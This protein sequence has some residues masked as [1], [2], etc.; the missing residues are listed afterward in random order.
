MRDSGDEY[1]GR[2]LKPDTRLL[3]AASYRPSTRSLSVVYDDGEIAE[4]SVGVLMLPDGALI[5]DV[6][7][8]EFRRGIELQLVDGTV[9]DVA[10][11]YITWLTNEAYRHQYPPD[12][13]PRIGANVA[14]LRKQRGMSQGEL[15][16]AAGI[17]APNVSRLEAGKHVP[18]LDVLLRI[19]QA[20]NVTLGK[21]VV[22]RSM[23]CSSD[24]DYTE[25]EMRLMRER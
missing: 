22:M 18:T 9:H 25:R 8:D 16:G 21:L 19:A 7:L 17:L 15:A 13:G 2:N 10:A 20:L 3:T 11:D 4:V 5:K 24:V 14:A 12:I 23:S 6:H 1:A